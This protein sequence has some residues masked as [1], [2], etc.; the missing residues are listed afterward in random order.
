[1]CADPDLRR[2][3]RDLHAV[4]QQ[5][6]VHLRL[7]AKLVPDQ[8]LSSLLSA[9]HAE[10]ERHRDALRAELGSGG[11]WPRDVAATANRLGFLILTAVGADAA[12][13]ML[14]DSI[15]YEY[16]E[17]AAYRTLDQMAGQRGKP[18]LAELAGRIAQEEQAMA[19]RLT[20]WLDWAVDQAHR[21][22]RCSASLRRHLQDVH[23]LE[24]QAAVLLTAASRLRRQPDLRRY[25]SEELTL[26][27]VQ[28]GRLRE[29]LTEL[30]SSPSAIRSGTMTLAGAAW[31]GV[32]GVQRYSGAKLT[33]FVYAERHL[34]IASYELL[35]R[36][37]RGC[38]DSRTGVLARD[39]L[40]Q[41][42]EAAERMEP[43]LGPAADRAAARAA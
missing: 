11:S 19:D 17:V 42:R 3:L 39:L 38:D 35:A 31:G 32:W 7:A 22:S 30:N 20:G 9:H 40:D 29:R 25:C 10:T 16:F 34:Q 1:M 21:R 5:A 12:G 2:L 14:V 27:A 43:L 26:T 4:E 18:G 37:A 24:T 6:L 15:T 36:E 8:E 23:A 33:C 13:K 41:E 28:R